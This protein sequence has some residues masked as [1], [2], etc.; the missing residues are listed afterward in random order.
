L[1]A[2]A[3]AALAHDPFLLDGEERRLVDRTI[4]EVC[5][6]RTWTLHALNVRTNHV[7]LVVT[8]SSSTPEQV[9]TTLK[10]WSTR[11]LRETGQVNT[12]AKLWARHGSTRYLW[13]V[14]DVDT[15]CIYVIESQGADLN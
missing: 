8:A 6:Y 1:S 7:H 3:H 14:D 13:T 9:L 15:A 5:A 12:N 4:R 10:A 11:R 2:A